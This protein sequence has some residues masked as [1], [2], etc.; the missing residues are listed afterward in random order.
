MGYNYT[1]SPLVVADG[2]V[3]PSDEAEK[4]IQTARPGHRAPHYWLDG[5]KSV[6]ELLGN[7]FV[8]RCLGTKCTR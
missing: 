5:G 8:L 6:I 2:S 7:G 4:Y 3:A 1:D